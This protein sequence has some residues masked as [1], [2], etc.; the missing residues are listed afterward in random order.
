MSFKSIATALLVLTLIGLLAW[1]CI[2]HAITCLRMALA[3]EQTLI[4]D[5]M[6]NQASRVFP[7]RRRT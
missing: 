1:V 6:V 4:F 3:D 7:D 2:E 5:D